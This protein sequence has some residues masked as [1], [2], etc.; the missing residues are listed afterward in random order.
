[1]ND[2]TLE[3]LWRNQPIPEL[4]PDLA[5]LVAVTRHRHRRLQRTLFWRD[6]RETM[7]GLALIPVWIYL[8]LHGRALWTW[9]LMIPALVFIVSFL[10]IDRHRH[11]PAQGHPGDSVTEALIQALREVEHQIWLLRHVHWWYLSPLLLALLANDFDE[12]LRGHQ[13]TSGFIVNLAINLAVCGGVWWLNRWVAGN[14][15]ETRRVELKTLLWQ[16][17]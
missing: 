4:D 12:F 17:S 6:F 14:S 2:E 13:P 10:L 9:Y 5:Q 3:Q 8:G 1:M 7:V 16:I 15:L 11:G